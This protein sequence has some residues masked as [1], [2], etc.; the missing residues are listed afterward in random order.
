M[1]KGERPSI[2]GDGE[3]TRDFV[4]VLD[5]AQ[6]NILAAETAGVGGDIFNIASEGSLTINA[7]VRTINEILGTALEPSYEPPRPGD[8]LHSA[9]DIERARDRLNYRPLYD[10]RSGLEQTV[11]WYKSKETAT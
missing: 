2:Y 6:A 4:Y 11:A 5:I 9:A 7:L 10:F 8:I 3:Q 1:V